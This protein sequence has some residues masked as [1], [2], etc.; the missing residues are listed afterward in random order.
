MSTKKQKDDKPKARNSILSSSRRC[1]ARAEHLLAQYTAN[2]TLE[3]DVLFTLL[4]GDVVAGNAAP[5]TLNESDGFGDV[6]FSV[7]EPLA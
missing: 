1:C 3:S 4:D 5:K 6:S 2:T 7:P